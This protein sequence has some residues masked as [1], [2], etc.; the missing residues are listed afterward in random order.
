MRGNM[1]KQ[2]VIGEEFFDR[3]IEEDH[4]YIDKT[5]LIKELLENKGTVTLITRPRRFGKS[6]NMSML[7]CFFDASKDN[8]HLFSGLKIMEHED[9]VEKHMGKYPVIFMTLKDVEE[10][11]YENAIDGLRDLISEL[12][13]QHQYI[14]EQDIL[15]EADKEKFM[16]FRKGKA[17]ERILKSSIKFLGMC[18]HTYYK[19]RAIILIDE[20]DVP[21]SNALAKGYYQDMLEFMRGFLGSAFKSNEFLEFGVLTGVQRISKESLVSSF[22]NPLVCGIMDKEFATC[23]GFTEDEVKEACET[24]GL[25]EEY[26]K[27]KKWYDGYRFGGQDIYNPWG[28]TCYLKRNEID[29]YWAN[30]GSMAIFKDVFNK[31]DD[32]LKEELAGLITGHPVTMALED[33]ITYPIEYS[34]ADALWTLLLNA[35]YLK[36]CNG[37]KTGKFQAELV[38]LEI[39]SIFARYATQW[40]TKKQPSIS[41]TIRE[42]VDYL[43][44][45]DAEGVKRTLNDDLLNNPSCYDFK[46]ENSYHMFIYGILLAVSGNYAVLSNRESGK[47]RADCVIKPNDKRNS[48]VI[49]EFKHLREDPSDLK[50]AAQKGLEQIKEKDYVHNLTNDGYGRIQIYGIAFHKKSCE[51][52]SVMI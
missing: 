46:E 2:I 8:R 35:G 31:G 1:E 14:L 37:A 47:G 29:E 50:E 52:A 11:S 39:C 34:D 10:A 45:G 4:F 17:T 51:V 40:L 6:L 26:G 43:L 36:P 33:G 49:V 28:I 20:Y 15:D 22:N 12:Y 44:K 7:K 38:N 19:K 41:E 32:S 27:V 5:L 30:T 23:F 9:I 16:L 18:L 48:A 24:Y 42:F 3:I 13:K 25:D 21:I